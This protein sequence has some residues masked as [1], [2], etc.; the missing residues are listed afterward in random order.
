MSAE[1]DCRRAEQLF[2]DHLEQALPEPL[3]LDLEAHLVVCAGCRR[4]RQVL[5]ETV[6]GLN[7]IH[8][9]S[10][11]AGLE[12][13]IARALAVAQEGREGRPPRIWM[14][15]PRD[16]RLAAALVLVASGILLVAGSAGGRS[17]E[18]YGG[19]LATLG[20][21]LAERKDRLVE[22]VRL[23]RILIST[24]FSGRVEGVSQRVDDYR[25][26]LERNRATSGDD[27]QSD[28]QDTPNDGGRAQPG[29]SP[30]KKSRTD[31]SSK[32]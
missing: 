10:A 21:R 28:T 29:P 17:A 14:R 18:H 32:S 13:G 11:P 9:P 20:A 25:R 30:V 19:R 22:N 31:G 15:R 26:L 12:S 8:G 4:L 1:F 7:A 5:G 16:R 2:S 27:P 3:R 23:L 24:T 6:S